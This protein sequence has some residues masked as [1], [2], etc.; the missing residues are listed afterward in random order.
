MPQTRASQSF[1]YNSWRFKIIRPKT[2]YGNI[3]VTIPKSEGR[4]IINAYITTKNNH[5]YLSCLPRLCSVADIKY[6]P[7]MVFKNQK[8]VII[9]TF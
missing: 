2:K 5:R 3:C 7:A 4:R 8:P 6:T 9:S 1:L